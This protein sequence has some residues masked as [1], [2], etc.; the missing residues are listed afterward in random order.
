[1]IYRAV[2]CDLCGNKGYKNRF[3]LME[4]LRID[5]DID[6]LI[7]RRSTARELRNTALEKGFLPLADDGIR[8]VLEGK[9]SLAEVSRVVDL[10]GRL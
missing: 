6:E 9:T 1:V 3:A 5:S 2:G 7:A 10:T 8:R 4:L